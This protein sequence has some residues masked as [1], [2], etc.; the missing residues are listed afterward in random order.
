MHNINSKNYISLVAFKYG[1]SPLLAR[2]V[3]YGSN[4]DQ[5]IDIS[6]LFFLINYKN[7][8]VL[9]DVGNSD[10]G[11]F[12]KYGFRMRNFHKP[13]SILKEYG[14]S[15]DEIT[16]IF[17]THADFDHIGD[18]AFYKNAVIYIQES[19]LETCSSLIGRNHII[20]FCSSMTALNYFQLICVGGHTKGSSIVAFQYGEFKYVLGGDACYVNANLEK[21][22]PTGRTCDIEKSREFIRKYSAANAI[23]YFSHEPSIVQGN[24]QYR[25]IIS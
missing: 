21:Q 11:I 24:V 4:S 1:D 9:V 18:I 16:D 17:V 25:T 20:T 14:L 22:I 3:F 6:W 7:H 23:V 5:E 8:H 19:E 13:I 10:L 15:P 2:N 12:T